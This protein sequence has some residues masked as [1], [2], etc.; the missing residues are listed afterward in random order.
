MHGVTIPDNVLLYEE[1]LVDT[2]VQGETS[3][4][5]FVTHRLGYVNR[6]AEQ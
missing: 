6:K 5:V 2:T 4:N 1:R 3:G